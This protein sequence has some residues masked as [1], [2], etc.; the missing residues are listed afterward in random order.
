MGGHYYYKVCLDGSLNLNLGL[1]FPLCL[2]KVATAVDYGALLCSSWELGERFRIVMYVQV[3]SFLL[4]FYCQ[5][6]TMY[7]SASICL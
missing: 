7:P 1:L 2:R 6:I 4:D 3:H 5:Q